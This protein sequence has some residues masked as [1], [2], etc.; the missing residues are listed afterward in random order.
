MIDLR[1]VRE[2]TRVNVADEVVE[3]VECS[4]LWWRSEVDDK[5]LGG[6]RFRAVPRWPG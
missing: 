3:T 4:E 5:A 1:Q 2:V 6:A